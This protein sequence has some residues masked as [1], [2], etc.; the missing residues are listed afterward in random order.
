LP[1]Y[2]SIYEKSRDAWYENAERVPLRSSPRVSVYRCPFC[3]AILSAVAE[4]ERHLSAVH[5]IGRP[6]LMLGG[7]EPS[8]HQ[9]LRVPVKRSD[10]YLANST[11]VDICVDNDRNESLQPSEAA[12]KLSTFRQE[13]VVIRVANSKANMA[14]VSGTY[15]LSFRVASIESLRGVEAAF[16]HSIADS[17]L[18]VAAVTAFLQDPRCG[19]SG[20]DYAESLAAFAL[21]IL[22]K[23]D[24]N[25]TLL[26]TP[27]H[28]YRG[29]YV[30]AAHGLRDVP[31]RFAQL[32]AK[33]ARFALNDF[34]VEPVETGYR[35]LDLAYLFFRDPKSRVSPRWPEDARV[36]HRICPVDHGTARTLDFTVRMS[37]QE[38][39]SSVLLDECRS[40]VESDALDSADRQK[41]AAVWALSAWRLGAKQDAVEPLRLIAGIY[42]FKQWAERYLD[43]VTR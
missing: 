3:A 20:A 25:S 6:F 36:K 26:S 37:G 24:T 29:N 40:F 39:W 31:R 5:T 30:K 41:A 17:A 27:F 14:V 15:Q 12:R 2:S 19:Q 10:V 4:L 32:V 34:S 33:L 28:L 22:R 1:T 9:V 38:R 42:P 35:E 21:A 16:S 7:H 23:E 18:S 43:T 11:T 13:D 8:R